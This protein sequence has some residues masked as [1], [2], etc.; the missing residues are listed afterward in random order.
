MA[1]ARFRYGSA[2]DIPNVQLV[3]EVGR[4]PKTAHLDDSVA[5]STEAGISIA[6]S[7]PI[8]TICE[9]ACAT[10][11]GEEGSEPRLENKAKNTESRLVFIACSD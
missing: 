5:I 9:C 10:G 8:V 6:M 1:W 11:Q 4:K 2:V 3:H 7:L